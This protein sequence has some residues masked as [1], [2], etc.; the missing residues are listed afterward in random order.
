[1]EPAP[2]AAAPSWPVVGVGLLIALGLPQ[3]GL[4]NR[5]APG[6]GLGAVLGRELVWWAVAGL[7][8]LYVRRVERLPLSSVGIR[9]PTRGTL[10]Y[11]LLLTVVL[12]ASVMFSFAVLF[13]LLG[14]KLNQS[15][16][17][18]ITRLPFGVRCLLF[19]RAAVVEEILY[20][21]YPIERLEKRTGST[22]LA[23]VVSVGVFTY[24]HLA[25][26]GGAQLIVVGFGAVILAGWY[27]WRRDLLSN[28][29]AHFL[30]DLIGFVL[31]SAQ[32]R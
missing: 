32:T 11:G 30:V 28:M 2:P 8:L 20:R 10:G 15:A 22:A 31:A 19:L 9:R 12:M 24:V 3:W 4:G 21:G 17:A 14:L 7:L 6:E 5:L 27:V 25:G 13:P 18:Q 1:M 26:W 23:F 16:V 29:L